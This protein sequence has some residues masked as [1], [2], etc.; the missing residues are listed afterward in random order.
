MAIIE[1]PWTSEQVAALN[2]YQT[3]GVMHPFTCPRRGQD[4]HYSD[5]LV[6]TEN[7]WIC[8]FCGYTQNW[9]HDFM[10]SPDDLL[11]A[12]DILKRESNDAV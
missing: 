2:R 6:A 7:G 8:Q 9:A 11:K 4:E 3:L 5:N 1:A 10:L 12:V